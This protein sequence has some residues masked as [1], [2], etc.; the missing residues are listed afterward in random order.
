MQFKREELLNAIAILKPGLAVNAFVKPMQN[1]S[2]NGNELVTFNEQI[3]ILVP[4]E[5]DF[6][7]SVNHEDLMNI[8]TKLETSDIEIQV[9]DM[10]LK[11]K[12]GSTEAGL[13]GASTE[14]IDVNLN[15]LLDQLPNDNNNHEWVELPTDFINGMLLCIMAAD[16]SLQLQSLACLYANGTELICTDNKRVSNYTLNGDLGTE[17]FIRTGLIKELEKFAVTHFCATKSWVFFISETGIIFAAKKLYG[18]SLKMYMPMFDDF[19][20][21]A[22]KL[23]EGLKE[24]VNAASVMAVDANTKD[25]DILI[26]DG[27]MICTTQ[28]ERGWVTTKIPMKTGKKKPIELQVSAVFL[29]QILDLPDLMMTV[30]EGK[31]LF[32]S[33][34]FKHVL[35]HRIEE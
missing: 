27:E 23:P 17:F 3:A 31:S 18:D 14:E 10:E 28:N 32:T 8:L 9:D 15:L 7:I 29:Q 21:K 1:V 20:G 33:G 12:A 34:N 5:T 30:G 6:E 26:K 11:I 35:L 2:F 16:T 19:K 22:V 24:V 13:I 4:F 25:M